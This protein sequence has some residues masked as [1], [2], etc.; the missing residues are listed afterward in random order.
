MWSRRPGG[1][2]RNG[3]SGNDSAVILP[4][5][6][7]RLFRQ[8]PLQLRLTVFD[9]IEDELRA[10]Q[11]DEERRGVFTPRLSR[12]IDWLDIVDGWERWESTA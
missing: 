6:D 7:S 11:A 8:T 2:G 10:A 9:H 12:C 3:G 5:P 1:S 4:Y